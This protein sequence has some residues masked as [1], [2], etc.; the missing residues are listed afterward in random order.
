MRL[1]V[2]VLLASRTYSVS[3]NL[4]QPS[5]DTGFPPPSPLSFP[6]PSP[7]SPEPSL[8]SLGEVNELQSGPSAGSPSASSSSSPGYSVSSFLP[9]VF[10]FPSSSSFFLSWDWLQGGGSGREKGERTSHPPLGRDI[11]TLISTR[12]NLDVPDATR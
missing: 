4:T 8:A 7:L 1:R 10:L 2:R 5:Q 6:T 3:G 11:S 12:I 9:L